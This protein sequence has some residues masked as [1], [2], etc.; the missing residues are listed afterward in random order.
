MKKITKALCV[1]A[2]I[3][4]L[5]SLAIAGI[6]QAKENPKAEQ[7]KE[8]TKAKKDDIYAQV[9][10]FADAVSIIRSEYVEDTEAKKVVYG[11]MKGMLA[12][13]DDFSQ[14]MEPDEYKEIK[15]ET[16]GEFGGL[17]VEI[18]MRDGIVTVIA[19]ISGTPAESAGIKAADKIVKINGEITKSLTLNDVVKKMRG[20]PNTMVTLTLWRE[21]EQKVFDVQIKRAIIK[22]RSIKKA[23]LIE[24]KIGYVKLAEFQENTPRDL[25]EALKK[26]QAQGMDSLILDLRNNPGGLLDVSIDVAERFLP[27]DTVIVSTKSRTPEQ[28]VIFKAKG[29]S[30]CPD[31]PVVVL[32][33]GGS[34]SA[35]EIVAG[36][37]QDNKRGIIL[38]TKTFGKA[39]VQTVIPLNDG[40]ALRLTT[41]LY[42]TPSGKLIR[43]QGII[44]DVVVEKEVAAQ[45][46]PE[47]KVDIFERLEAEKKAKPKTEAPPEGLEEKVELDNQLSRAVDLVKGLKIYRKSRT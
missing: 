36:A 39:S 13:L 41:A 22:I 40:S 7:A 44:P 11:A 19:P 28:N 8:K 6:E 31:C 27:K 4:V 34:A 21:S 32:V 42:Y 2:C 30:T 18:G 35:S 45:K 47:K 37:I 24:D 1:G 29:K 43:D 9:E 15:V 10:L 33:N 5:S 3:A 38:G 46:P 26:L 23:A 25:D 16:K 17:G 12:S 20:S 14:F